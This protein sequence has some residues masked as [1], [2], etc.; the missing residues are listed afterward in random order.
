MQSC[1]LFESEQKSSY[2]CFMEEESDMKFSEQSVSSHTSQSSHSSGSMGLRLRLGS[3]RS[4]LNVLGELFKML[5]V[6]VLKDWFVE[7]KGDL[8]KVLRGWLLKG[9]PS[10]RISC[11]ALLNAIPE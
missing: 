3:L 6:C 10:G 1:E 11:R 5:S 2:C 9:F 7:L 4:F 8:W